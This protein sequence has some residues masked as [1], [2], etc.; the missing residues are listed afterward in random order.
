M[1]RE[2]TLS[3]IVAAKAVGTAIDNALAGRPTFGP[4][5]EATL[6]QLIAL[7]RPQLLEAASVKADRILPRGF[8]CFIDDANGVSVSGPNGSGA[9]LG[10]ML[11][12]REVAEALIPET[13]GAP[14]PE[15]PGRAAGQNLPPTGGALVTEEGLRD[16]LVELHAELRQG[17]YQ[18]DL[19]DWPNSVADYIVR[20]CDRQTEQLAEAAE[21]AA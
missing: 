8:T 13:P 18:P 6:D 12:A 19:R 14:D 2:I 1:P 11:S 4:D 10:K 5:Y 15:A 9:Y 7:A 21:V 17:T 20:H 16:A 3:E